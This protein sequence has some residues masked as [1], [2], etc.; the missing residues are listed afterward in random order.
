CPCEP[1]IRRCG[2]HRD[3][4]FGLLAFYVWTTCHGPAHH[5]HCACA[6]VTALWTTCTLHAACV[7]RSVGLL[8]CVGHYPSAGWGSRGPKLHRLFQRNQAWWRHSGG[9][10]SQSPGPCSRPSRQLGGN[11]CLVNHL[12]YL[13]LR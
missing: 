4:A 3:V 13:D 6:L 12:G 8:C 10:C 11:G 7:G 2:N 1:P 9:P 5:A